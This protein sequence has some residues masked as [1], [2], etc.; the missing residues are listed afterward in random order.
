MATLDTTVE[1]RTFGFLLILSLAHA[2][3]DLASGAVVALLPQLQEQFA[4]SYTMVGTI[5]LC[6]SLTSSLTQPLFGIIS[7]RAE[8]R[9]LLPVS[10]LLGG[11]GIA[12]VGYMPNYY[13]ILVA[14]I[15]SALG[16]ASFHP[17]GAHAAGHLAAGRRARAMA[18]YSV[19][20]N[21]GFALAPIYTGA[22]LSLG[23]GARGMTWALVLPTLLALW[24]WRLLPQWQSLEAETSVARKVRP[25][26]L[27]PN[28]WLGAILL[29]ALVIVRQIINLG[30]VTYVPFFWMDVLGHSQ[31]TARYVQ[32]MYMMAGVFGTLLGAPLADKVGTKRILIASFAVLLPLQ[33]ALPFLDGW[34]LLLTL[35]AAGFVVVSTFTTTLVMTQ[36]YM[37]RSVGLASGINLGLA[38]GMGGVGA[39]V[40][41]VVADHWGLTATLWAVAAL[42]PVTLL[43]SLI[44]PPVRDWRE[45]LRT[46]PTSR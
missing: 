10:L 24:I 11:A 27:P 34:L 6:S 28:N 40:L 26:E 9:W 31:E 42:V 29:T 39:Q 38:F 19:G 14:V 23:T 18:I 44:L 16:T 35:F 22:L 8:R 43:L 32:V 12:A 21:I 46:A 33:L 13:L 15:I 5:M 7:D 17:E 20:G 37:P 2:V 4:L 45:S 25:E 36:E 1:R 41:G 3:V 30:V